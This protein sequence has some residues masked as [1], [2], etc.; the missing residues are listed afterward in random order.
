LFVHYPSLLAD[1]KNMLM[2]KHISLFV[3]QPALLTVLLFASLVPAAQDKNFVTVFNTGGA[4]LAYSP[5]SGI[6]I[7][8]IKGLAFKDLNRNGKLDTYEDWRLPAD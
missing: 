6:K 1:S 5:S 3:L 7:L 2:K 8:N 4:A